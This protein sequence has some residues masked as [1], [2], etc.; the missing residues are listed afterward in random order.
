[1]CE[2]SSKRAPHLLHLMGM[3]HQIRQLPT[4]KIRI[5]QV[6][7]RICHRQ[8]A[9]QVPEV[10]ASQSLAC[11]ALQAVKI[12]LGKDAPQEL[13]VLYEVAQ[14]GTLKNLVTQ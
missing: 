2:H 14:A 13:I 7:K 3:N 8:E 9:V 6:I 12:H 4:E 10:N 11:K 5:M 1:M